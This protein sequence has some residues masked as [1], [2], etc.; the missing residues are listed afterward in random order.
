MHEDY[1]RTLKQEVQSVT[2]E[3]KILVKMQDERRDIRLVKYWMEDG[4]LKYSKFTAESFM[5]KSL[6]AQ[7]SRLV[8]K[9]H[10]LCHIWEVEQSNNTTYQIVMPLSQR[11]LILQQ[12][13]YSITSGNLG[14]TKTLNK[15]RQNYNWSGLQS[16]VSSYVAGCD[17]CAHRKAPLRKKRGPMQ[18]M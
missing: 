10:L 18:P 12:M 8:L 4:M 6:W 5:V 14:V 9:D 1:A 17:L 11:R 16:D 13:H 3:S 2:A 15:I 7:W